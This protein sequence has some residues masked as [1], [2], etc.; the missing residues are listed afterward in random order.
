MRLLLVEDDYD[1]AEEL[2]TL[3]SRQ[4]YETEIVHTGHEAIDR[5]QDFDLVLLDLGLPDLDGLKVC[6]RLHDQ[7]PELRI[8]VLTARAEELDRVLGLR[9]GADDY[10]VK[11]YSPWELIARIEAVMRRVSPR[12]T[13]PVEPT[14]VAPTADRPTDDRDALMEIGC[15]RLDARQRRVWVED[16][17]VH[18]TRLEFDLL[19]LLARNVGV[20]FTREQIISAVWDE[21]WYGSTRTIDVHISALRRKVG[22]QVRI[23][24][25]RGVGFRI[26]NC[27]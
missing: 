11:P 27:D 7:S 19:K 9:S 1:L 15:L 4:G 8:I 26:T 6:Q 3:L 13:A 24:T 22:R 5:H 23:V 20:V 14:D 21:D 17:E 18:L 2:A 12:G 25:V 10:V 16:S